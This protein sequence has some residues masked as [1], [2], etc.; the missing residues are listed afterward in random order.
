MDKVLQ[1][2]IDHIELDV[3][4]LLLGAITAIA[5]FIR[6]K[7]TPSHEQTGSKTTVVKTKGDVAINGSRIDKSRTRITLQASPAQQE[8]SSDKGSDSS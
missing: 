1:F 7:S 8:N 2:L 3:V 5:W 4:A 6:R